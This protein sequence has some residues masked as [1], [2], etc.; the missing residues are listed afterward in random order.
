MI[1]EPDECPA[2]ALVECALHQNNHR[3]FGAHK[4][5]NPPRYFIPLEEKVA[6]NFSPGITWKNPSR[7]FGTALGL[8]FFRIRPEALAT[9]AAGIANGLGQ[10]VMDCVSG[11]DFDKLG[12]WGIMFSTF[13]N[14][15]LKDWVFIM[16]EMNYLSMAVIRK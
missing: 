9:A 16:V 1:P 6:R 4:S 10:V 15:K 3:S 11:L 8:G 2:M 12:S 13:Q 14:H 5:S 7:I